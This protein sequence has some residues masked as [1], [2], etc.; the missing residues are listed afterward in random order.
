[1]N[2]WSIQRTVDHGS[3]AYRLHL[4][5]TL[6]LAGLAAANSTADKALLRVT[7]DTA[8]SAAQSLLELV[9]SKC[10]GTQIVAGGYSQGTAVMHGVISG[11]SDNGQI[12]GFGEEKTGIYCAWGDMVY[13]KMLVIT[14]A[15]FFLCG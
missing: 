10:P 4:S 5:L 11:P 3:I 12:P 15:H 1:M 8:I 14:A 2:H 6:A 13:D 7:T 9:A